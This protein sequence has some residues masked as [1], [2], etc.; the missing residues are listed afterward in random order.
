VRHVDVGDDHVRGK[1]ANLLERFLAIRG[2]FD[3]ILFPFE[4]LANSEASRFLVIDDEDAG[5]N[6]GG[7]GLHDGLEHYRF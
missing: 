6:S 3:Q 1:L 4:G 5:W 2:Q 7:K